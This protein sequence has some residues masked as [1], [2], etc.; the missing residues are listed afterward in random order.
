M[1]MKA[2]RW[3]LVGMLLLV[4][5]LSLALAQDEIMVLNDDAFGKMQ[6]PAVTFPHERHSS[7]IDCNRC[8]HDYDA[9]GVNQ[10]GDGRK[11]SECHLT[12]P[13]PGGNPVPLMQA[14]HQQCK[15]CHGKLR[16][17]QD[18]PLPIL[19]GECHVR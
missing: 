4:G 3:V 18:R 5:L 17:T 1:G 15:S 10:G 12:R 2:Y 7:A 16:A 9:F 11:C 6:R 8:H 19:C 14:F 13:A